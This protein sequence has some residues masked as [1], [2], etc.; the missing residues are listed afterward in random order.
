VYRNDDIDTFTDVID[1][2]KI[3]E[4]IMPLLDSDAVVFLVENAPE[5]RK[6]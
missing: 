4:Q 6:S 5:D 1:D 2:K 3:D